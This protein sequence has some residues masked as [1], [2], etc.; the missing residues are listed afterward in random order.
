M[1]LTQDVNQSY[2]LFMEEIESLHLKKGVMILADMG[3][4]LDLDIS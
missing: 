3:S 1:P 2:Q 4:L